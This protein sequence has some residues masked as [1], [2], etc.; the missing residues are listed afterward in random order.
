MRFKRFAAALDTLQAPLRVFFRDDDAGWSDERLA[1]LLDVFDAHRAPIDLA[2]IP[3]ALTRELAL[4]LCARRA[5]ARERL[6]LHQHGYAHLNH[7]S[8]GRKCEFG[9]ARSAEQQARDVL[10][11]QLR[12]RALLGS[13][14][15]IFTPPW[16]RCSQAT[17]PALSASGLHLSRDVTA[18]PLALGPVRECPV[19]VDWC[20]WLK[21]AEPDLAE[22]DRQLAAFT[23]RGG[24]SLGIMLHH[25]A[26]TEADW[27]ALDELLPALNSHR[28]VRLCLMRELLERAGAM[29]GVT[30]AASV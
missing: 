20:K 2:V 25:A 4:D 15:P 1:A 29:T 14:D 23:Q 10:A 24:A 21:G 9:P 8:M 26:M 13:I 17:L 7:E 5:N 19:Q 11:G 18:T 28:R 6:G 16:N 3:Q 27:T 12:L 30:L 22:L